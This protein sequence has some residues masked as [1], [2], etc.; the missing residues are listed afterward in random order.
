[1]KGF[2]RPLPS[3]SDI[4]WLLEIARRSSD[5]RASAAITLMLAFSLSLSQLRRTHWNDLNFR[6]LRA[7]VR[8]KELH[9]IKLT[10]FCVRLFLSIRQFST[11]PYPFGRLNPGSP[12]LNTLVRTVLHNA[13]LQRFSH[14]DLT[15]WSRQQN[16]LIRQSIATI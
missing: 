14:G 2:S 8:T 5:P 1:M 3:D 7:I 13:G 11:N 16:P 4:R 9:E 12:S 6:N 15:E 10:E